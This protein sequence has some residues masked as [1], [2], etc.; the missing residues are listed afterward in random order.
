M[1]LPK[2]NLS[3]NTWD[4][5]HSLAKSTCERKYDYTKAFDKVRR[6]SLMLMLNDL[7][8]GGKDLR[9]IR[10]LF[11]RQQAAIKIGN[12]LSSYIEIK[13]GVR[14]RCVL[15]PDLLL[16]YSEVAMREIRDKEGIEVNEETINNIRYADDTALIADSESKLQ[17]IVDKIV[18]E[19][20]K[21]GLS[22]NVKITYCVVISKKVS[23][24]SEWASGKT[25]KAV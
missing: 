7:D 2:Y 20:E 15:S 18:A 19:S 24:N 14:Q 5:I 25:S 12:D 4:L 9:L 17:G 16:L 6:K 8:I 22:L 3:Y 13:R 23:F 11:W 21:L 10:D 1:K